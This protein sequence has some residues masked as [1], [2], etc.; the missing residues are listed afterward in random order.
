MIQDLL[1][2]PEC[3]DILSTD[4]DKRGLTPLIWEHIHPYGKSS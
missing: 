1:D 2:D 4:A 3:V